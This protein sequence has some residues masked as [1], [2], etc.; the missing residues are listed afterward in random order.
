MLYQNYL[1]TILEWKHQI[2]FRKRKI[3][4]ETDN[5]IVTAYNITS[6]KVFKETSIIFF[7]DTHFN[8]NNIKLQDELLNLINSFYSDVVIF[9]GDLVSYNI[10]LPKSIEF[11]AKIN[12]K[13]DKLGV[14]GNWEYRKIGWPGNIDFWVKKFKE[15]NF[16]IL[17]DSCHKKNNITFYGLNYNRKS[18]A[19][20]FIS[21][22]DKFT[23]LISHI[24]D[25]ATNY[26]RHNNLRSIDLILAGHTHGG[27]IRIPYLNSLIHSLL[28]GK[29]SEYGLYKNRHLDTELI[30]TNGIGNNDIF[31]IRLFCKPEIVNVKIHSI[32]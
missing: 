9:G 21:D 2:S 3:V 4:S 15:A 18:I 8:K 13:A 7:S 25:S 14:L 28:F 19:Q 27:Q 22:S 31:D 20:N 30:I 17:A 24:P 26:I 10:N 11:L 16:K 5:F 1:R 6:P 32:G 29:T 12:P 23:C